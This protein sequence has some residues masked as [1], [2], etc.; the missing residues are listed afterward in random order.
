MRQAMRFAD[1]LHAEGFDMPQPMEWRAETIR[2]FCERGEFEVGLA[3]SACLG[4]HLAL[5]ACLGLHPICVP[6]LTQATAYG[7][8]QRPRARH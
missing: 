6:A 5:K 3:P 4:L 7:W 2:T 1:L 8:A